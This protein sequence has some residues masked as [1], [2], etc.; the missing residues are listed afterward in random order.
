MT[1]D[2]IFASLSR[3][4]AVPTLND[5]ASAAGLHRGFLWQLRA[6][7]ARL[8]PQVDSRLAMVLTRCQREIET[9]FRVSSR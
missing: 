5:V 3:L 1:D 7:K 2:E 6:G 4:K 8:T 9:T